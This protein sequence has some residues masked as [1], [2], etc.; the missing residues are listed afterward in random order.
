MTNGNPFYVQPGGAFGPGLQG[1]AQTLQQASETKRKREELDTAKERYETVKKGAVEAYRT[2]DPD[3]IAEYSLANPEVSQTL[4]I[5]S[6]F[7]SQRTQENYKEALFSVYQN[8]TP[9]NVQAIATARKDLLQEE[10]VGPQ[11]SVETDS[12][13]ER[14]SASP[15][16]AKKDVAAEIAFRYPA[17]WKS[18]K[19]VE[20]S[21]EVPVK[22][23]YKVVGGRLVDLT[24]EGGPKVV[25]KDIK[26]DTPKT[27][28]DRGL[29]KVGSSL[30]DI[31]DPK[32]PKQIYAEPKAAPTVKPYG[33]LAKLQ[34]DL[35]NGLI[36]DED[37][38]AA[39]EK[40]INPKA[41]TKVELTA[42]A[43]DGDV[44]AKTILEQ[45]AESDVELAKGKAEAAAIGKI[46][47]LHKVMDLE[48]SAQAVLEGRETIDRVRNTFGVPIQEVVRRLVLE[49]DPNFNFLQPTARFNALKSSLT[50]QQKNR[51]MMGSFVRNINGQVDKL[52]NIGSDIVSRVG[53]RALD[54]PLRE[55]HTRFI[56]SGHERVFE[57]YMKEIS[58]EIAK[59]AQGS[60]ASVAQLPETNRKEW[61][62]IHDV[63]L[64][65]RSLK[66][67]LDGTREMA[68]I[69]LESVQEE[70]D[71]TLKELETVVPQAQTQTIQQTYQEGQ[72]ATGPGGKTIIFRN[73]QWEDM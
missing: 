41:K 54:I 45:M 53:V 3:I 21:E 14:F 40:I 60:A 39:K 59:L 25:I 34:T 47:G 71:A 13:A 2:G 70:L 35:D 6:K 72:T 64:S 56:G 37:Y 19:T 8:P 67:I 4:A 28:L 1:L 36:T 5:M 29:V 49:K 73:G 27:L 22:D 9:E 66:V 62:R 7:K 30:V 46:A 50:Q 42:A 15:E 16:K 33:N 32:S 38:V 31:S 20:P 10:G 63:N 44:E 51:G 43:L 26:K 18:L 52:E 65:M 12:F 11:D 23:Q 48:G 68:N 58:A 17:E 24:A 61:E 55:L 69:R 57:A